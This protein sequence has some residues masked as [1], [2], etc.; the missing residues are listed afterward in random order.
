MQ[1]MQETQVKSVGWED[2]LE[3]ETAT[4]SNPLQP[5][6]VFLE[7][8]MDRGTW[9]TTVDQVSESDMT[10]VTTHIHTR[11]CMC[12]CVCVCVSFLLYSLN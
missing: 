5:T 11:V 4:H 2:P 6:P 10:E 1:E 3:K 8:P 9:G 7:N 12:V